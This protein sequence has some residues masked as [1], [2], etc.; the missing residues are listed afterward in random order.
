MELVKIITVET[1]SY[2]QDH[3]WIFQLHRMHI[4]ADRI[5]LLICETNQRGKIYF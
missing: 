3:D 1:E 4:T 2:R 5:F